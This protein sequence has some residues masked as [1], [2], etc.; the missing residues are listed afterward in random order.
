MR[1]T[2]EGIIHTIIAILMIG[3]IGPAA[4][5]LTDRTPPIR[6]VSQTDLTST[7]QAGHYFKYEQILYRNQLC[8]TTVNRRLI[9]SSY[10]LHQ[11][12]PVTNESGASLTKKEPE[13]RVIRVLIPP[14]ATQGPA[15][16]YVSATFKCNPVHHL[17]PI[18]MEFPLHAF[19]II[20]SDITL[21]LRS[22]E[23]QGILQKLPEIVDEVT[24][25]IEN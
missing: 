9:D 3:V 17:W 12:E 16:L 21:Q 8:E 18:R 24:P 22:L 15:K 5:W 1:I 19:D 20:P 11:Y 10:V 25:L 7:V 23:E 14:N 4:Y 13:K 2:F 6:L